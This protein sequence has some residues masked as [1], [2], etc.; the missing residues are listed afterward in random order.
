MAIGTVCR[1]D[2]GDWMYMGAIETDVYGG[3]EYIFR[4]V[5]GGE[6]VRTHHN[7]IQVGAGVVN[8]K[9]GVIQ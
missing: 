5:G 3:C 6:T 4:V 8:M 7:G 2:G 1:G 9:V